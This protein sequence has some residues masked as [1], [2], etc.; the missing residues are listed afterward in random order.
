MHVLIVVGVGNPAEDRALQHFFSSLYFG[1]SLCH[2]H[3]SVL[4]T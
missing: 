2:G 4:C 1:I 3:M